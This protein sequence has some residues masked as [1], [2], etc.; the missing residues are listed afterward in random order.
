MAETEFSPVEEAVIDALGT[1]IDPE[2]DMDLVNLGLIY[3]V[4]VDDDGNC[5]VTMTLTTMGC[6][7]SDVLHQSIE[8]AVLAVPGVA[9]CQIN[10]VWEPA[11]DMS[12]MSR[13][14]RLALGIH[15]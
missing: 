10:L 3:A 6:P 4:D 8:K 9:T 14:A 7:L 2:I 5:T 1:V 15:M 13:Y 12:R 11:W